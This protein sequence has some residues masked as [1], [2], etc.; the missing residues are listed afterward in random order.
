MRIPFL[1]T[2]RMYHEMA[3]QGEKKTKKGFEAA[4]RMQQVLTSSVTL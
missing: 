2:A 1:F 3:V 4:G